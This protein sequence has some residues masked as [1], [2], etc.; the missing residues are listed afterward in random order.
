MEKVLDKAVLFQT[1]KYIIE[2]ML[3]ENSSM[4]DCILYLSQEDALCHAKRHHGCIYIIKSD[5]FSEGVYGQPYSFKNI[6]MKEYEGVKFMFG[7]ADEKK[8]RGNLFL[9]A[10]FV[11]SAYFFLSRYEEFVNPTV[12]DQYGIFPARES[13]LFGNGILEVPVIDIYGEILCRKLKSLGHP[14]IE[15]AKGFHKLYITHDIDWPFYRYSFK[16]AL[17]TIARNIIKEHRFVFYPVMNWMGFYQYNPQNTW[18]Y[19]LDREQVLKQQMDVPVESICFIIAA[20]RPDQYTMDYICDKKIPTILEEMKA[21][22]AVLGLHTSYRGAESGKRM[23]EEKK[24]LEKVTGQNVT[25]QRNHYLRQLKTSDLERYEKAGITDDFTTGFNEMPGFRLGTC[26]P[27]RWINPKDG[28]VHDIM[29]HGLHIMDG[30]LSG[31]RPYQLGLS[32]RQAFKLCRKLI[33]QV[34]QYHGEL[35]VLWHNG[36][37][38]KIKGNYQKQLY[39]A[40]LDYCVEIANEKI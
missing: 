6:K 39:H 19:M 11:A 40:V 38:D 5:F 3:Q 31:E 24:L 1:I 13:V 20:A 9:Y 17:R 8:E 34:Y 29:L 25:Y 35:C 27:V 4:A 15:K 2:F 26:H 37:F 23:A 7:S 10:D 22:G 21:H 12:R 33:K 28:T 14:V 18:N 36:M 32:Y 30:S 16:K